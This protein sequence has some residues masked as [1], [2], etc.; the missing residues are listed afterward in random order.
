M[1]LSDLIKRSDRAVSQTSGRITPAIVNRNGEPR[2]AVIMERDAE[3][4]LLHC[5]EFECLRRL[6]QDIGWRV[7]RPEAGANGTDAVF[8]VRIVSGEDPNVS[9]T[10]FDVKIESD[11]NLQVWMDWPSWAR[12]TPFHIQLKNAGS[13]ALAIDTGLQF[14]SRARIFPLINGTGVE[15]GPGLNPHIL[16][17]EKVDVRYVESA[18]AEEWVRNYKKTDKPSVAE[19]RNLWSKYVVADA[20]TLETIPDC[21]LDFIYSNHV[22]EHLMNPLG[23]LANWRQKLA[24]SGAVLG[25]VPD[26][27]YIFDLRQPPSSEDEWRSQHSQGIWK[28]GLTQYERWCKYTAP[29]NTPEDLIARRYS[30]HVHFYTSETFTELCRIVEKEGLFKSYRV[31]ASRNHRDFGFVLAS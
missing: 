5:E 1:N 15:I 6:P 26:C 21:S 18:S 22:F 17:S 13:G 2:N 27:R 9:E 31:D 10:I 24:P 4:L 23:V 3:L 20:Q 14:N 8:V 16:P 30:I 29:Y 11:Q 25:V 19:L 12:K 28:I 7:W